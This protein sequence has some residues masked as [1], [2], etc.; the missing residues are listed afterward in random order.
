MTIVKLTPD[1][2]A[3]ATLRLLSV[4]MIAKAKSGHPGESRIWTGVAHAL[5]A[6]VFQIAVT[7]TQVYGL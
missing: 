5:V 7:H 1:E 3:V 2:Q 4:D 6:L